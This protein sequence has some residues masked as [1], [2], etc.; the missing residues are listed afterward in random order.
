MFLKIF[1]QILRAAFF[2]TPPLL[3]NNQVS[4]SVL[5]IYIII[6]IVDLSSDMLFHY[7]LHRKIYTI[8]LDL[9]TGVYIYI[10]KQPPE[11]F[12]AKRCS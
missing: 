12:C 2:R 1:A 8:E 4:N 7:Y 10:Q 5:V 6:R 11:V 3:L 9:N